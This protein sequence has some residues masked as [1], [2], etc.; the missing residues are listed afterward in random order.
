MNSISS[1]HF[2]HLK[3]SEQLGRWPIDSRRSASRYQTDRP[4]DPQTKL[5]PESQPN[6]P[7]SEE[8]GGPLIRGNRS[9]SAE[10]SVQEWLVCIKAI[11]QL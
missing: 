11:G 6:G 1:A 5:V 10:L 7:I 8:K 9:L 4:P 3:I 2:E